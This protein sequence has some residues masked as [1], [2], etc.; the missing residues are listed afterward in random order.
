MFK[1]IL[2][3]VLFEVI[4]DSF[5]GYVLRFKTIDVELVSKLRC[6]QQTQ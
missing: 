4:T 1:D 3:K 5:N 6:R 2:K